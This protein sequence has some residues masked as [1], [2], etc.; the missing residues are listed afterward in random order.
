MKFDRGSFPKVKGIACL[1]LTPMVIVLS[2]CE[3]V[4]STAEA[5]QN[6][7]DRTPSRNQTYRNNELS[8]EFFERSEISAFTTVDKPTK[9]LETPSG[10][11]DVYDIRQDVFVKTF[12]EKAYNL[13]D[14]TFDYVMDYTTRDG[15]FVYTKYQAKH[16]LQQAHLVT[17]S[18]LIR[19][20]CTSIVR[21][22]RVREYQIL[23]EP[24]GTQYLGQPQRSNEEREK[25]PLKGIQVIGFGA[26]PSQSH[27]ILAKDVNK[28]QHYVPVEGE[29]E[30]NGIMTDVIGRIDSGIEINPDTNMPLD[31]RIIVP[32]SQY[33][34][35]HVSGFTKEETWD[36]A[37]KY[38]CDSW[39]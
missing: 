13:P 33:L 10:V 32:S 22:V 34:I 17:Y 37:T 12:I 15:A 30:L 2:A 11:H 31:R 35:G 19:L 23:R 9:I 38:H 8:L 39:D 16:Y 36:M 3:A 6:G 21:P 26:S 24:S 1:A 14:V 7:F 28:I 25:Y 20:G 5:H 18:D 29:I 4:S 27:F